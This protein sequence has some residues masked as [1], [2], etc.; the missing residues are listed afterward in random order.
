VP[1]T[2]AAQTVETT[3]ASTRVASAPDR[4]AET[5]TDATPPAT[6]SAAS[7]AGGLA[8]RADALF[9]ALR[10]RDL[11]AHE[12]LPM[13]REATDAV[14]TG[15]GS[16]A[17]AHASRGLL[18]FVVDRDTEAAEAAFLQAISADQASGPVR[19]MF[20]QL[21]TTQ[22]RFDVAHFH[23]EQGK[24][25]MAPG[26]YDATKGSIFFREPGKLDE[27]DRALDRA[28]DRNPEA[29]ATR[30]LLAR[31]K[32]L[33]G[34]EDDAIKILNGAAGSLDVVP[35]T[36][37]AQLHEKEGNLSETERERFAGMA[38]RSESGLAGALIYLELGQVDRALTVLDRM[39]AAHDPD[40]LWL[41]V[42]PEWAPL[43]DN[44]QFL[45]RVVKVFEP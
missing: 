39:I 15:G 12:A 25:N 34:D 9:R 3:V 6:R 38:A 32:I 26:A 35:W 21:L 16:P 29:L 8:G 37:Y 28:L 33:K 45:R 24:D 44:Q 42:D 43:K 13:L 41:A 40:L 17:Q 10:N 1:P 7:P 19:R 11:S 36:A 18:L 23:A 22:A 30:I 27:A 31:T 5:S 14:Q 4:P 2:A 20:A